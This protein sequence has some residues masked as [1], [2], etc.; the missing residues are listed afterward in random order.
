M[1]G[2]NIENMGRAGASSLL[3]KIPS[4]FI[5]DSRFRSRSRSEGWRWSPR[6]LSPPRASPPWFCPRQAD[7]HLLRDRKRLIFEKLASSSHRARI[8]T[9]TQSLMD[10]LY[11][12]VLN[13]DL[14]DRKV[15]FHSKLSKVD[16]VTLETKKVVNFSSS[17][18][19]VEKF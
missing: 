8:L 9:G 18:K 5:S 1:G 12:K 15:Y 13:C 2:A 14:T 16:A 4:S 7:W 10:W 17:T 11:E 19:S 6:G 3:L